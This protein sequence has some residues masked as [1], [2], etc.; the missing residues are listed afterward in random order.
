M[1][2]TSRTILAITVAMV[3]PPSGLAQERDRMD[4]HIPFTQFT[5]ANGLNVIVHEDRSLPLVSVNLWYHVGSKNEK[6]GRTGFAHLF[7]HIMFEGSANVPE[8]EFDNLLE[9][10]GGVNNG[11]TNPDR[12]NYWENVPSNAL[13]LALWLEADRMGWLLESMDQEKLDIQRDVVKNE[14]RQSYENRPYGLAFE[15]LGWAMFPPD[16]PYHWPT[17][18]SMEDLSAA[19]LDD[20]AEFFK[21][22]YAP[23]NASLAVAGDVSA[24][25]VR[26][27]AETY[28]GEIPRGPERPAVTAADPVLETTGRLVLEDDVPLPRLYVAWHTPRVFTEEDAALDVAGSVLAEGKSSRLHRRLVYEQK[29]A[30]DVSAYQLS[31]ELSSRFFVVVTGKPDTDLT[32]LEDAV[33]VELGQLAAQGP[34]EPEMERSLSQIETAFAESLERV[35]GFG[36]KAD[37]L[38]RYYVTTGNPGYVRRDLARF[39]RMSAPAVASAVQQYLVDAESVVLSVVPRGRTDLAAVRDGQ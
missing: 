35:G 38:N 26:E 23:N 33:R 27:L 15:R 32:E 19:T 31:Q 8:G 30:Q 25:E 16:H 21:T 22:Y 14:R 20:V 17:I 10:A 39:Q 37:Q 13:E 36:G 28:F 12:T 9:S 24:Q 29:V 5:L 1:R 18:G 6:P 34:T 11:S 3:A 7:E 2:S 4:V